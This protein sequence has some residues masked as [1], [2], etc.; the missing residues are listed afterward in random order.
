[1][2]RHLG[3]PSISFISDTKA[4]SIEL[5]RDSGVSF[6]NRDIVYT[7]ITRVI[8]QHMVVFHRYKINIPISWVIDN[9]L[10]I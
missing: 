3:A 4:I 6:V 10:I 8:G 1:M 9:K 5:R 7:F 2:T